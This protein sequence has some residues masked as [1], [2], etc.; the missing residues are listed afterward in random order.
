[1]ASSATPPEDTRVNGAERIVRFACHRPTVEKDMTNAE[2]RDEFDEPA[3]VAYHAMLGK[4][5]SIMRVSESEGTSLLSAAIERGDLIRLHTTE[6]H[7]LIPCRW[8][9]LRQAI[10][11]QNAREEPDKTIIQDC[12]S[13]LEEVESDV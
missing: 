11:I 12:I 13:A 10:A 6:G 7:Y 4:V 3:M 5:C 1:M 8:E 2:L 9:F